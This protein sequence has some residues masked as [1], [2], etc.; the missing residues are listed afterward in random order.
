MREAMGINAY[1]KPYFS[2]IGYYAMYLMPPGKVSGGFG[3][4]ANRR[5]ASQLVPLMSQLAAQA[6]N[7][8]WQWYVEQ[9]GGPRATSGY[10]GF[11]RGALPEVK[12]EAPDDLPVSKL[13]RGIGQAYL[14]STLTDADE[15]VQVIFKSSPMGTQS[16]GSEANNSFV[17]WAYGQRLL[18]RT[19]RYYN[20]GGPHHRDW[21]WSTRSVN[22]ITINGGREQAKRTAK[23]QGEIVAFKTTPAIDVVIG[24]AGSAYEPPLERFTRAIIFV[25]PKLII[26]YD[27]L[28]AKEPSTYEYW[29]HAVN[30]IDVDNQHRIQV[31][32]GDVVCDI[33]FLT[34]KGL[35]FEQTDQ[36]DPNPIPSITLREWH[37]TA[38]TQ[39]KQ[40]RMEFVTLYRPHKVRDSI[41]GDATL[42]SVPGGYVLKAS[43]SGQKFTALLPVDDTATLEA[44]NLKTIGAIKLKLESPGNKAPQFFEV[45]GDGS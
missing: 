6:G 21:M 17:L 9:M 26:V 14:N 35:T 33:D 45:R 38:T 18:I 11:I 3:D 8:H 2:R 24:E 34:P 36:Y 23:A 12:A 39:E 37:L 15:D 30:K 42:R 10:I 13:F 1:D 19:G 22:N 31:R 44:D 41:D 7:E 16:H 32:N 43:Q 29:L 4:G 20:Y 27:R 40:K 25:K 5:R 28:K